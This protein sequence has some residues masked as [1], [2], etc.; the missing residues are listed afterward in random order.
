MLYPVKNYDYGSQ[1]NEEWFWRF[2]FNQILLNPS[3]DV[4][5]QCRCSKIALGFLFNHESVSN[6]GIL[7]IFIPSRKED[8]TKWS[9][10]I[11]DWRRQ[12]AVQLHFWKCWTLTFQRLFSAVILKRKRT[13]WLF[14]F[15]PCKYLISL[16]MLWFQ[17][18]LGISPEEARSRRILLSLQTTWSLWLWKKV[19]A[20]PPTPN[21]HPHPHF[22]TR[23]SCYN[24]KHR[25]SFLYLVIET[26]GDIAKMNLFLKKK[27][28]YMIR[29]CR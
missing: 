15:L 8:Q 20:P 3:A 10:S 21:C 23:F 19:A 22:P 13:F 28:E 11:L 2:F 6:L 24:N 25:H 26:I 29:V 17:H 14:S 12:L 4:T 16:V 5:K 7:G 27:K 18:C 9:F 1:H